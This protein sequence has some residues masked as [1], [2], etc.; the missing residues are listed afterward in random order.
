MRLIE[1]WLRFILRLLH[2]E[3]FFPIPGARHHHKRRHHQ[4]RR[5]SNPAAV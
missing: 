2:I 4:R 3:K 5:K 1:K